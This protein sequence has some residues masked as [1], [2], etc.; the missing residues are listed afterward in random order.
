MLLRRLSLAYVAGLMAAL[1][2]SI[3]LWAAGHYGL[4]AKLQVAIA[5]VLSLHWL[6]PR[7]VI[8]GLWGLQLM[9]PL[10]RRPIVLACAI[11]V[12]P[13]LF[14]LLWVYPFQ[15]GQDWLGLELG[16]LTPVL[17]SMYWLIWGATAVV[18]ARLTGQ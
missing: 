18:W 13:A 2:A 14:Q 3:A 9:L 15:T 8:G 6:Y 4:N 1:V 10:T 17:I 11:S 7:L 5:P 12:A 16:L